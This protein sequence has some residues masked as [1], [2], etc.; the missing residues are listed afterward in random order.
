MPDF[1]KN[2]PTIKNIGNSTNSLTETEISENAT[3]AGKDALNIIENFGEQIE[4]SIEE[5]VDNI[6]KGSENFATNI[7]Q[8]AS[9]L[10]VSTISQ[11]SSVIKFIENGIDDITQY[12][13]KLINTYNKEDIVLEKSIDN[14]VD[15]ELGLNNIKSENGLVQQNLTGTIS[16]ATQNMNNVDKRDIKQYSDKKLQ[17]IQE[18]KQQCS[19]NLVNYAVETSQQKFNDKNDII[20]QSSVA[21]LSNLDYKV[22]NLKNIKVTVLNYE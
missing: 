17:K 20:E 11:I 6:I 15:N 10:I 8:T 12:I 21:N 13:D 2:Y 4:N 1:S 9:G 16:Q 7:I 5:A 19:D 22:I 14:Y 3:K 18:I